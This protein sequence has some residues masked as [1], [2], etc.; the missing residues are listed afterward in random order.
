MTK[1]ASDEAVSALKASMPRLRAMA[2]MYAR[3]NAYLDADDLAQVAA[4]TFCR[5]YDRCEVG[6]DP[7]GY[8]RYKAEWEVKSAAR[9]ERRWWKHKH[10]VQTL[11]AGWATNRVQPDI[12]LR[13]DMRRAEEWLPFMGWPHE[14]VADW[15]DWQQSH[16]R[17]FA[18]GW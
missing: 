17:L 15:S 9:Q 6:Y 4:I 13:I 12:A 3:R 2:A 8:G 11:A 18:R 7:S 16:M 10:T 5:H 1:F 14:E